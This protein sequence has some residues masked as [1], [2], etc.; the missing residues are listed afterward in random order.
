MGHA[1]AHGSLPSFLIQSE[2]GEYMCTLPLQE[3]KKVMDI[4]HYTQVFTCNSSEGHYNSTLQ[5]QQF[6]MYHDSQLCL[7]VDGESNP[8]YCLQHQETDNTL[9]LARWTGLSNQE[10]CT[11]AADQRQK[12]YA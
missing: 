3:A 10:F 1:L 4:G 7:P 11:S 12:I 9:V 8:K 6:Q 2:K 5:P